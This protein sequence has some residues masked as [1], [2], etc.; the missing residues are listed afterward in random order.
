MS[1][2]G[3]VGKSPGYYNLYLGGAHDGT[4][5]NKLYREMLD[6]AGI[7]AAL[8]PIFESY[9]REIKPGE[10]FGDYVLRKGIVAATTHGTN[11]HA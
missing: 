1:E 3:L 7:V 5:L 6:E 11:F 4:R 2:I 9:S 8:Q 10:R